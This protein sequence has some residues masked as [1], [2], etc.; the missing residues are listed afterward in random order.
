MVT[1][2]SCCTICT[3]WYYQFADDDAAG[4]ATQC[5]LP[6]KLFRA[7]QVVT[8]QELLYN[9]DFRLQM[10]ERQV[11]R[12]AGT[13]SDEETKQLNAKIAKL[14]EALEG[15]NV[16][17][18][19]LT[20]QVKKAEEDLSKLHSTVCLNRW[21]SH[22]C[23]KLAWSVPV[24]TVHWAHCAVLCCAVLCCALLCFAVLS[25]AAFVLHCSGSCYSV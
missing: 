3:S 21:S 22:M 4:S 16:E 20:A 8:Q 25:F 17:H 14:T 23:K 6:V 12:A 9:V 19:M 7:L 10:M 1:Q 2:Q 24:H 13:R 11:A 18:A 5:V 15:V